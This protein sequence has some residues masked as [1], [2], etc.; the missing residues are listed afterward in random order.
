MVTP[1]HSLKQKNFVGLFFYYLIDTADLRSYCGF[2]LIYY[3]TNLLS[4]K[5]VYNDQNK[6]PVIPLCQFCRKGCFLSV[7]STLSDCF[8][9]NSIAENFLRVRWSARAVYQLKLLADEIFWLKMF[10]K[11]MFCISS[12]YSL[13][14]NQELRWENFNYKNTKETCLFYNF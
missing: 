10:V 13:P 1:Q 14:N 6:Y 7:L 11:H 9:I 2:F 5:Y 4:Q 8:K 12:S 3:Y